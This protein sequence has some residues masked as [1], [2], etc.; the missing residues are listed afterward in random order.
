MD[1]WHWLEDRIDVTEHE[2]G[3]EVFLRYVV[4][5]GVFSKWQ[6]RPLPVQLS[7]LVE[8]AHPQTLMALSIHGLLHLMESPPPRTSIESR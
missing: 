3:A 6:N 5:V 8:H 1:D 7:K 2:A 4:G